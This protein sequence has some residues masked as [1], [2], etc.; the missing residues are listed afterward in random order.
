MG[1]NFDCW[2]D[3]EHTELFDSRIYFPSFRLRKVYNDF[4]EIRLFE[5]HV[6]YPTLARSIVKLRGIIRIYL[7]IGVYNKCSSH[8]PVA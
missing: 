5:K 4:N 8:C 1:T 7:S 6:L 3:K 2:Q